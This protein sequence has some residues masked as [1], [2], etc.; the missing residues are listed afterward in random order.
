MP[1]ASLVAGSFLL[2]VNLLLFLLMGWDKQRAKRKQYRVAERKLL[3]LGLVG[4]GLGG[5]LAMQVFRHKTQHRYFYAVFAFGTV[6]AAICLAL[7]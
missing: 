2:T 1:A 4:G 5:L 3:L 7:L 6:A